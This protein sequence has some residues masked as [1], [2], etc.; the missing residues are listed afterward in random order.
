MSPFDAFR[1][2]MASMEFQCE[3]DYPYDSCLDFSRKELQDM[4]L[5]RYKVED[6]LEFGSDEEQRQYTEHRTENI[7][8]IIVRELYNKSYYINIISEGD[9]STAE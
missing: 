2:Q 3:F 5:M 8:R 1:I 4:F 7:K 6:Y 9:K